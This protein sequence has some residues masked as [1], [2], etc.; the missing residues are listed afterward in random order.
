MTDMRAS[1]SGC[2]RDHPSRSG[3]ESVLSFGSPLAG[4]RTDGA[5]AMDLVC[6]AARVIDDL[7]HRANEVEERARWLVEK[8]IDKLQAA[9]SRHEAEQCRQRDALNTAAAKLAE[10]ERTLK[11][12]QVQLASAESELSAADT[13]AQEAEK[14]ADDAKDALRRI[15]EAIRTQLLRQRQDG[16][17]SLAAAA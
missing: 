8:A 3:D 14:R 4:T 16:P 1:L 11:F 12:L 13:R 9:E 15:E 10:A 2:R 6:Q 7:S 5:T 17:G